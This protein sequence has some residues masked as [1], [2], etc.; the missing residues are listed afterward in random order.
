MRIIKSLVFFGLY[1]WVSLIFCGDSVAARNEI[2][3][4]AQSSTHSSVHIGA[5]LDLNSPM[6]LMIDSCL[7]MALS[8]F[9]S[10]HSSYKTRLFLH[11]K[12]AD[13]EL[14]VASAG[15]TYT[16][17]FGITSV[18]SFSLLGTISQDTVEVCFIKKS[19]IFF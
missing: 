5:V 9:Y 15:D 12:N 10:V 11:V 6:G 2:N 17:N 4:S 8:D 13:K 7:S 3:E 19:F 18:T 1:V 14:E 16:V